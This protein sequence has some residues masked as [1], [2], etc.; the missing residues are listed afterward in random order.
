MPKKNQNMNEFTSSSID[1]P[2]APPSAELEPSSLDTLEVESSS[3]EIPS[4][5]MV[6]SNAAPQIERTGREEIAEIAEAI[7]EEKWQ[8][9]LVSVGDLETWKARVEDDITA[10]KQE[11]MRLSS[12]FNS[13][14]NSI[15]G[16]ISEYSEGMAEVGS[17][18]KAL[19]KVLQNIISPLTTNIKELS[20]ITN[21]LKK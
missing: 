18:I 16:K 14:Q 8:Q 13:L 3:A 1:E 9:I 4:P 12:R 19:E 5:N 21:E 7:V 11:I 15:A 6:M 10:I 17:E 2:P 20:R